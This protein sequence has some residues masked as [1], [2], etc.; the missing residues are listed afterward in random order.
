MF[1]VIVAA[2]V[3]MPCLGLAAEGEAIR[4]RAGEE[5]TVDVGAY[6]RLAIG[7]PEVAF[8]KASK[9]PGKLTVIGRNAG[10]TTL[11]VW[12]KGE[13]RISY[14]VTVHGGDAQAST[15]PAPQPTAQTKVPLF[16]GEQRAL[17]V[18][19]VSRIALGDPEIA[20]VRVEKSGELVMTGRSEGATSLIVWPKKGERQEYEL[21]VRSTTLANESSPVIKLQVG[22]RR[23]LDFAK[24]SKIGVPDE[25]I[26]D[27]ELGEKQ[28]L[29][30]VGKA[31]GETLLP[32]WPDAHSRMD[33]RVVVSQ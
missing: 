16:V 28:T 14:L 11:Q 4:L 8:V 2:V 19:D 3:F 5:K 22:E 7:Q 18:T 26:A 17:A 23:T 29:T 32:V 33:L 25:A 31:P 13:G 12:R 6:S 10:K 27:V 21:S 1:K 30:L 20:E 15:P 24:A 9:E